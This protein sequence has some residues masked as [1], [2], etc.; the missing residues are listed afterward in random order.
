MSEI[1]L[2]DPSDLSAEEWRELQELSRESFSST[3]QRSQD[4]IDFLV[5]WDYPKRYYV[6]HIDPNTE[7]GKRYNDNQSY[8]RPKV[9]IAKNGNEL[10]GS[11]YTADNVS[12]EH[13][14]LKRLSIVKNYLWLREM[15]VKPKY[16]KQEVAKEIGA[17]LLKSAK[18]LQPVT[19]YIL[20]IEIPFL[21]NALNYYGFN[22]TKEDKDL[23]IFGT[24][25]LIMQSRMKASSVRL[26]QS[27]LNAFTK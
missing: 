8:S 1:K 24:G 19:A 22:K 6:S 3:L 27:Y 10:I 16:Q 2:Y 4:E 25:E 15:S 21:F 14:D 26:V 13:Q 5:G 17:K 20:P 11:G 7:V 9:A 12:G 18:I 23:D